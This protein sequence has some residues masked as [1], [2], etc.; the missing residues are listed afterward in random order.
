MRMPVGGNPLSWFMDEWLHHL[1]EENSAQR[2]KAVILLRHLRESSDALRREVRHSRLI[3]WAIL[4]AY[5]FIVN[6][7]VLLT[8]LQDVDSPVNKWIRQ[9]AEAVEWWQPWGPTALPYLKWLFEIYSVSCCNVCLFTLLLVEQSL[10]VACVVLF[11]EVSWRF[12]FWRLNKVALILSD[13]APDGFASTCA[14][15]LFVFF[16]PMCI[17]G[18]QIEDASRTVSVAAYRGPWLEENTATRRLRLIVMASPPARFK[19][20]GVG[21]LN[22]PTCRRVMRSWF[23][24]VQVLVNLR[25]R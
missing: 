23:Q 22:R 19:V 10:H 24:F 7:G 25:K 8:M 2:S 13:G 12:E 16:V 4:P 5:A 9:K 17:V 3:C 20:A 15:Y 21:S 6:A 18:Q 1:G 11:S 14:L